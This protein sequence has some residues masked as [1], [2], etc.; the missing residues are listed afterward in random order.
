MVLEAAGSEED[1]K[2]EPFDGLRKLHALS[3]LPIPEPM[4]AMEKMPILHQ[5]VIDLRYEKS[6]GDGTET[7][8]YT[9]LITELSAYCFGSRRFYLVKFDIKCMIITFFI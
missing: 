7:V 3:G 8:M 1:A 4:L 9:A 5:E 6:G 2:L